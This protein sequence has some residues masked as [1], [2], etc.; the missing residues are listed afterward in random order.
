MV[1]AARE[2]VDEQYIKI[3]TNQL[4]TLKGSIEQN[5]QEKEKSLS[6][7]SDSLQVFRERYGIYAADTQGEVFAEQILA[8]ESKKVRESARL[9]ALSKM[10]TISRD[11][12]ALLR[13]TVKGYE[14][15]V[16]ALKSQLNLFNQGLSKVTVLE[17]E[18]KEVS[19]RLSFQRVQ[20]NQLSTAFD[21]PLTGINLI[22]AG[23]VPVRKTRPR[24]SIIVISA[25]LISF[26]FSIIGLLLFDAYKEVNW[27]DVFEA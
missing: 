27:K 15:E 1:N 20:L 26:I 22:E 12:I 16:K 4:T 5:I 7:I 14:T 21:S 6:K 8:A 9:A 11:T 3:V 2:K 18:Q 10:A 19:G 23:T 24:R 17:R 25:V 13:A